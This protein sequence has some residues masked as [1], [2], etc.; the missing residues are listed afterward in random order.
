M[1]F[2]RL[3]DFCS[4]L[5]LNFVL[6]SQVI[7]YQYRQKTIIIKFSSRQSRWFDEGTK[8]M[9]KIAKWTIASV[10]ML[11]LKRNK[12]TR[13]FYFIPN[14]RSSTMCVLLHIN[15][16]FHSLMLFVYSIALHIRRKQSVAYSSSF[17]LALSFVC[18]L[19]IFW[20]ADCT[21]ISLHKESWKSSDAHRKSHRQQNNSGSVEGGLSE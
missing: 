15:N 1:Y 17:P 4:L 8:K 10:C 3:G 6:T 5:F 18:Q 14:D 13:S 9:R 12:E 20:P 16:S 7:F 11:G 2:P 19:G 21:F